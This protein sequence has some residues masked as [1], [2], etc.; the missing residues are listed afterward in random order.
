MSGQASTT[1]SGSTRA[2]SPITRSGASTLSARH[3]PVLGKEALQ[4]P[5]EEE[6]DPDQQDRRHARDTSTPGRR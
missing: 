3:E 5:A 4:F 1:S 6:V 2:M